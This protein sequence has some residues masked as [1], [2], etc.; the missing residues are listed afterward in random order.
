MWSFDEGLK[1]GFA[2]PLV[3][4]FAPSAR[5]SGFGAGETGRAVT[6]SKQP[7]SRVPS[8]ASI[9]RLHMSESLENTVIQI[10]KKPYALAALITLS[11]TAILSR[12]ASTSDLAS[13]ATAHA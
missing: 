3:H 1:G 5:P 6:G 8:N 7:L 9:R 13:T 10:L 11:F 2:M 4:I 12:W